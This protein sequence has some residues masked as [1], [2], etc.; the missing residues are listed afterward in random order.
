[1]KKIYPYIT[2]TLMILIAFISIFLIV[3]N[4]PHK[5]REL[6]WRYEIKGFVIY[7]GK[8]HPAIWYTDTIEVGDNYAK[9]QNSDGTEV[10]IPAPF[11]LIDH[12]FDKQISNNKNNIM[13]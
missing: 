5:K 13:D 4:T 2:S 6:R 12:K 10:V 9:Y 7:K 8:Q 11:I 3:I 1:M